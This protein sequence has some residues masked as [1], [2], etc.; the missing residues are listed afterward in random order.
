MCLF[1]YACG[2][3][4]LHLGD[5]ARVELLIHAP[6]HAGAE[7]GPR[8]VH[9]NRQHVRSGNRRHRRS[10]CEVNDRPVSR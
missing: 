6:R 1:R 7:I 8:H 3:Q 5:H 9:A 4:A 2:E 10:K